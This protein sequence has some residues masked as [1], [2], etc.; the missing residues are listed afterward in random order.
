MRRGVDRSL[1]HGDKASAR[2]ARE[3]VRGSRI[4]FFRWRAPQTPHFGS[5]TATRGIW[6]RSA[7]PLSKVD[8]PITS[9]LPLGVETGGTLS[10]EDHARSATP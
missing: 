5:S 7:T 2:S 8:L 3:L 4:V 10:V 9:V 6:P 1:L